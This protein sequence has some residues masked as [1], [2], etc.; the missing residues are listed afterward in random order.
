[1]VCVCVCVLVCVC[2][3]DKFKEILNLSLGL[4]QHALV[5]TSEFP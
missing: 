1:V 3:C 5:M 4:M 2:V